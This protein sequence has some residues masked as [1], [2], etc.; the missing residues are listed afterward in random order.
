MITKLQL[1][2]LGS[3]VAFDKQPVSI[4]IFPGETIS[5]LVLFMRL[6]LEFDL[7]LGGFVTSIGTLLVCASVKPEASRA[8][9]SSPKEIN[10]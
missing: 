8:N 6:L 1:L 7:I 9:P 10:S 3:S 5:P 2:K 4:L